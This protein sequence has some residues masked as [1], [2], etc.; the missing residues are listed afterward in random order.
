MPRT[1]KSPCFGLP[2]KKAKK[3]KKYEHDSR[4]YLKEHGRKLLLKDDEIDEFDLTQ[5]EKEILTINH[6]I[7]MV[8]P[9]HPHFTKRVI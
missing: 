5:H 9:N 3:S 4:G 7:S 1:P 2:E 8:Y 6:D